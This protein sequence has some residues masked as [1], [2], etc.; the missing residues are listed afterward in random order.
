MDAMHDAPPEIHVDVFGPLFEDLPVSLFE[1]L[2]NLT[3][4]GTLNPDEVITT[5]QRYDAFVMPTLADSEGYPGVVLEAYQAGLPVIASRI[6]AIPEILDESCGLLVEPGNVDDLRKAIL[7][8]YQND[9]SFHQLREG[10]MKKSSEF[11]VQY[12]A[13]RFVEWC[14]ELSRVS[15]DGKRKQRT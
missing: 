13:D 7:D 4:C 11:D 5:M 6:G 2:S 12:W 9:D 3:Y 15:Q 14:R 10:V 1:G 8:M